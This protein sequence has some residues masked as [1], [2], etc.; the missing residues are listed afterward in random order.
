MT[1]KL[2]GRYGARFTRFAAV[3][4]IATLPAVAQAP[5]DSKAESASKVERKNRAPVSKEIL[6]VTL[7]KPVE[8]TLP[9]GMTV[10]ILEDHR[11]PTVALDFTIQGAGA[12]WEPA[13]A[14]G[15]ASVAAQMLREGT[16][17]RTS[18]QI[19][20]EI[21]R[22]GAS[23]YASAPYG[24]G[25]TSV[26][27]YG[28][29]DNL[30]AWLPVVADLLLNPSY[31]ADELTKLKQ[32][33]KV[34]LLQ[35]RQQPG[36]LA[37]ER[38]SK[39]VYGSHPAATISA[40]PESIDSLTPE[41]LA[42]WHKERY[43][44]QNTI[45]G[46]AGDVN[47]AEFVAKLKT[48]FAKW[49]KS[50]ASVPATPQTSAAKERRVFVVDRPASVQTTLAI[51]NIAIERTSPDYPAMVVM[52]QILGAGA[53]GRLFLN[54]RE[55]KGYTYGVYS[56]FAARK[57]AGPFRAG[58]DARTEVTAGAMTEFWNEFGRIRDEKVPAGELD[59]ARRAVVAAFALSLEHPDQVLDFAVERKIYGLPADYWDKYPAQ[60]AAVTAEDVQRV[61]Q[62]YVDPQ[63]M[64][65]VA[66][67]D[68]QKIVPVLEKYGHVQLFDLQDKPEELKPPGK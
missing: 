2:A 47:A 50:G 7:P 66:V 61:A 25:A 44:P 36:F 8:M 62:K 20:E 14:H 28:L 63:T 35:Q 1:A 6:H 32:R 68:A 52:D 67:G 46:V 23:F 43:A 42:Q 3:I 21:D 55:A 64:Q 11:F 15:M 60:V 57:Y 27:A 24:D 41:K 4:F 38:F 22:L 53:A 49:Q 12:L 45:L 33:L 56:S 13:D 18:K 30:D 16:A 58:G 54:L 31:P 17:T 40:T 37:S 59:D 10:L 29:S 65:I 51:G 34:Q 26:G 5:G 19:N 9:N 39:A 48:W